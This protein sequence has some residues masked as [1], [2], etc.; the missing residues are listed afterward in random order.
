MYLIVI[1]LLNLT[2]VVSE[3]LLTSGFVLVM[4]NVR[5]E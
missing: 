2:I 1:S 5:N 4:S 3:F